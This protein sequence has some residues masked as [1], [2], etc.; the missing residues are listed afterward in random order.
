MW[1]VGPITMGSKYHK[2]RGYSVY[3]K[4]YRIGEIA[5]SESTEM[6]NNRRTAIATHSA[7]SVFA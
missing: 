7:R 4:H 2:T 6:R 5:L 1:V 3:K